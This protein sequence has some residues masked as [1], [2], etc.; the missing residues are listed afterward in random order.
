WYAEKN[1][2]GGTTSAGIGASQ[3]SVGGS[4]NAGQYLRGL[5]LIV[6]TVTA[7][8]TGTLATTTDFPFNIL[9]NVDLVNVDGSEIL[10]QMG[11][12][13]HYVAQKYTRP[14]QGDPASYPDASNS[15]ALSP[16][17][18]LFLQPEIRWTAGVLANTDTRSQYRFDASI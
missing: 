11:G 12:F 4:I 14:W 13:A 9:T 16:Q 15:T 7:G 2:Q 10:Y 6:R 18:T 5:R 3:T 17:F 8:T 1:N